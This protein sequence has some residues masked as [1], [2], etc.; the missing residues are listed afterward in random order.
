M[1]T[2]RPGQ[3]GGAEPAPGSPVVATATESAKGL[4]AILTMG[5]QTTQAFMTGYGTHLASLNWA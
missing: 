3:V 1:Q 5:L 2:L 4:T